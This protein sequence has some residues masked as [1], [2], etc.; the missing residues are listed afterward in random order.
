VS[1]AITAL[2]RGGFATAGQ[3]YFDPRGNVVMIRAVAGETV[4]VSLA[5]FDDITDVDVTVSGLETTDP[6]IEDAS[7]TMTLSNITAGGKAR[8]DVRLANGDVRFLNLQV[9]GAP[10]VSSIASNTQGDYGELV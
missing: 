3:S 7:M 8:Y 4:G 5:C 9:L 6:E 10:A 2:A 1:V